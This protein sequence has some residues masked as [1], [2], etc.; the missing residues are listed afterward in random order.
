[1]KKKETQL[2]NMIFK[3]EQL[4]TWTKLN[5]NNIKIGDKIK[6]DTIKHETT[7]KTPITIKP[8]TT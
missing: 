4:L 8:N 7:F 1:M 5:L 2:V 6:Y 3:H